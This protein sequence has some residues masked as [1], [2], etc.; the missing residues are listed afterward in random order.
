ML[1]GRSSWNSKPVSSISKT[2][3]EPKNNALIEAE[4]RADAIRES[5]RQNEQRHEAFKSQL[6]VM[7]DYH[8]EEQKREEKIR[9]GARIGGYKAQTDYSNKVMTWLRDT[10]GLKT[11][12]STQLDQLSKASKD[13]GKR[14]TERL[15]KEWWEAP[16]HLS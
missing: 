9:V 14:E 15:L 16:N 7:Q 8:K 12:S 11:M 1:S 10:G 5:M 2:T 13:V 6:K 3:P 4:K